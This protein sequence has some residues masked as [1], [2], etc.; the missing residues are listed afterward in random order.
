MPYPSKT[1]SDEILAAALEL[2]EQ[3]GPEALSMRTLAN[4]L[5]IVPNAIYRYYPDRDAL[6]AALGL[7]GAAQLH[8]ALEKASKR[9]SSGA[10][11]LA[12]AKA[13]LT[14]AKARPHLYD[15]TMRNHPSLEGH[16]ENY[17][18][19]WSFVVAVVSKATGK[20]FDDN[21]AVALWSYLHGCVGLE[22]ADV[23]GD[24]KPKRGF[25]VGLEALLLG[26]KAK[27]RA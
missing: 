17:A 1:S 22:R 23:L 16:P 9:K 15:L 10:S 19:L 8:L 6:E 24:H 13:Y 20:A 18:K 27:N 26:L 11:L 7:S 21:A 14:F 12:L 5:D 25:E 2:L 3:Q 4:K